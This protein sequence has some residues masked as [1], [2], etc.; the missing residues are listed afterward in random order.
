MT[1][2]EAAQMLGISYPTIKKFILN[3]TLKTT[4]TPGGHHRLS[5]DN[6][7]AYLAGS[8]RSGDPAALSPG[9]LRVVGINQLHGEV[10]S[11]RLSGLVAEVVVTVG[12]QQI[13]A[14]ITADAVA[15]LELKVGD[16][17][18]ALI[19]CSNVIIAH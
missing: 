1:P 15:E 19:N 14:I 10:V 2:R 3:G 18:C 11:V 6:L 13:T 9:S 4:K 16:P 5:E 17:V 12:A 7:Q 8:G